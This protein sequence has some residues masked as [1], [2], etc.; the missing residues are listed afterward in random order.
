MSDEKQI[1][2]SNYDT[3]GSGGFGL[4]ARERGGD[5]VIKFFYK[6]GAC[7]SAGEES[8]LHRVVYAKISEIDEKNPDLMVYTS[9]PIAFRNDNLTFNEQYFRCAYTMTYIPSVLDY[10]QLVHIILKEDYSDNVNQIIGRNYGEPVSDKNPSRGFFA[11]G[12][13]IEKNIL[14]KLPNKVKG[15]IKTINDVAFRM[16]VL[17]GTCIFGAKLIPIDA[18]YVLSVKDERLHVVVL[19]FGMFQSMELKNFI[20]ANQRKKILEKYIHDI[21]GINNIDLYFPYEEDPLFKEWIHGMRLSYDFF[22]SQIDDRVERDSIRFIG[23][24]LGF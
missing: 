5:T 18:E 8:A 22:G 10:K 14:R 16:G 1:N 13:Y 23:E 9:K 15:P 12:S 7:L 2:L 24:G 3:I 20:N 11:T 17:C 4:V 19:D 21:K 6:E